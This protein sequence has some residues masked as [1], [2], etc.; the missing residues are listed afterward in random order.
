MVWQQLTGHVNGQR[1]WVESKSG[2]E[3]VARTETDNLNEDIYRQLVNRA[4]DDTDYWA[5]VEFED[6]EEPVVKDYKRGTMP[7]SPP[8]QHP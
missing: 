6:D 1:V 8:W 4:H 3:Y 2:N 7:E 5:W